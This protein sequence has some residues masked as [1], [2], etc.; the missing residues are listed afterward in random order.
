MGFQEFVNRTPLIVNRGLR[1]APGGANFGF[2]YSAAI[3]SLMIDFGFCR[4][5]PAV[6][7]QTR[8][9]PHLNQGDVW[10]FSDY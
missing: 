9:E 5:E 7:D 3:A 1:S 6:I 10:M 2:D 8:P 4:L